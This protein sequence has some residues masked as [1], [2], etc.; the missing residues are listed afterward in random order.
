MRIR[1]L[2]QPDDL[3]ALDGLFDVCRSAD[4][5]APLG[6]HKYLDVM[7][8]NPAGAVGLAIEDGEELIGYV[9]LSP[10]RGRRT[11]GLEVAVH[12]LHRQ[13]HLVESALLAATE[14]VAGRGGGQ[15]RFWVYHPVLNEVVLHLG[16]REERRLRQLRMGLPPAETPSTPPGVTVEP[17]RVGADEQAWLQLNNRAFAGHPENGAWTLDILRDRIDQPWFDAA[18]FLMARSEGRLV[19]FCW[20]KLHP[21]D[22]GE[23]YIIAVDPGEQRRSLGRMLTLEGLWYL[24]RARGATAG[25]VYVDEDN[26]RALALYEK[27]GFHLDHV[28]RSYTLDV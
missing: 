23:I 1:S 16:F 11:W 27:L 17:F 8:G 4:G 18:G 12:P 5:H 26:T 25:M 9:H 28:D 24:H 20:T 22:L 10:G 6:E 14:A 7:A 2:R 15:I 3:E 19:G 21:E 13:H